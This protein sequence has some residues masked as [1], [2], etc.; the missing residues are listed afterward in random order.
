MRELEVTLI[1]WPEGRSRGGPRL[2]A[3]SVDTELVDHVRGHLATERRRE[4][5]LM[6]RH[7]L[8]V[9]EAPGDETCE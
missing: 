4:A 3:S 2:L 1:E 8:R 6:E 7:P 9:V 5:A